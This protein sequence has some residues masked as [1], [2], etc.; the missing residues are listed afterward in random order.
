[1][2]SKLLQKIGLFHQPSAGGAANKKGMQ[3]KSHAQNDM[4]NNPIANQ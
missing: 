3:P 4:D 1:M 2:E